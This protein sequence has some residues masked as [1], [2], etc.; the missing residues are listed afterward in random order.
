[1]ARYSSLYLLRLC[2]VW[3]RA[4]VYTHQG[5]NSEWP[6]TDNV[7]VNSAR[8]FVTRTLRYSEELRSVNLFLWRHELANSFL[9]L[10]LLRSFLK[11]IYV[12]LFLKAQIALL[13]LIIL[14]GLHVLRILHL[15]WNDSFRS[16]RFQMCFDS[17]VL[18]LL[19]G[20]RKNV[21]WFLYCYLKFEASPT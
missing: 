18:Y 8:R 2:F 13:A 12:I 17:S 15:T 10:R 3:S 21:W 5:K 7:P 11:M 1:M 19:L 14:Y 6:L 9:L 16:L 20:C 4:N